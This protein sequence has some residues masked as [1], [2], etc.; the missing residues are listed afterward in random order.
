MRLLRSVVWAGVLVM[1]SVAFSQGDLPIPAPPNPNPP[2]ERPIFL[3]PP[4][5]PPEVAPPIIAPD[6]RVV[7]PKYEESRA[8]TR[9]DTPDSTA[10]AEGFTSGGDGEEVGKIGDPFMLPFGSKGE[11]VAIAFYSGDFVPPPN[12]R[13]Q[14]ALRLLA[15]QR[16]SE[17]APA[18]GL[19]RPTVDALILFNGRL[20]EGMKQQMEEAG[21][22]FFRFYPYSA[23]QAR[24]PVDLLDRLE[25]TEAVRWVG[26]PNPVQKTA[27][28]AIAYINQNTSEREW[29]YITGFG[30]DT[31][32][33]LRNQLQLAGAEIVS[34]HA[35]LEVYTVRANSFQLSQIVMIPDAMF[36]EWVGR[37]QA[38]HTESMASHNADRLWGT[39]YDG[40]PVGGRSIK[41]GV[42]DS[43]MNTAH[44]DFANLSG[45]MFGFN[46]TTE[47]NWWNDLNAHGTHV[48]GTFFGQG[49]AQFRYRGFASGFR[50]HSSLVYDLLHSKVFRQDSFAEGNSMLEG[51][52]DMRGRGNEDIKRRIYNLSGGASSSLPGTDAYAREADQA[53]VENVLPVIAAGNGGPNASTIRT[54]GKAK[55][56]LTVGN[57][58]DDWNGSGT[59]TTDTMAPDSSRGPIEDTRFKP[60]VVAH[61][62]WIDST[63]NTDNAGYRFGWNGTSMAAPHVAGLAATLVQRYDW[64][65]WAIRSIIMGT[66]IDLGHGRNN[67][68]LGK[69]D[70]LLSHLAWNGGWETWFWHNGG[71]GD[72]RYIDV[73][74]PSGVSRMRVVL[75]YPDPP[76]ASGASIALKNDLDLYLQTGTLTTNASGQWSSLSARNNVEIIEVSN[77]STGTYRVKVHT[78]NLAE[79]SSQP[80]AFTI[81]WTL[82]SQSPNLNLS[83]SAPVAVK[84]ST[85][86]TVT[87]TASAGSYVASGV[88][89]TLTVPSGGLTRNGLT[90]KRRA[91]NGGTETVYFNGVFGKNMGNIGHTLSRSF[92]WSM[93]SGASEGTR[94]VRMSVASINGGTAQI[95]RTVIVDG[96]APTNWQNFVPT[97]WVSTQTPTC[98]IQVQDVLAGLDTGAIYY[99]YYTPNTGTQGPFNA[100]TTA[101]NG[102]TALATLR[103]MNVPF[104]TESSGSQAQI[105]FR[106][107]DRAGNFS[108]SGWQ[109]VRIDTTAPADWQN[110]TPSSVVY[111]T[112]ITCTVRVRD[113]LSGL[114]TSTAFYRYSSDGGSTWSGWV[115][116]SA[117]GANGTTALQTITATNVPFPNPSTTQNKI[118]FA[119]RDE[120]GNWGYSPEYT[121]QTTSTFTLTNGSATYTVNNTFGSAIRTGSLGG[122]SDFNAGNGDKLYQHWWWY[123]TQG[124]NREFALSN[125]VAHNQP[126]ANRIELTYEE[127]V[128]TD[129]SQVYR[130]TLIYE[131][132][133][134][135][136]DS[137]KVDILSTIQNLSSSTRT[138]HLYHY[139]DF[140]AGTTSDVAQ[141]RNPN[142]IKQVFGDGG[143]AELRTT[144]SAS[145]WEVATY[146]TLRSKLTNTSADDLSNAT[147]VSGDVTM[148]FQWTRSLT[149]GAQFATT[150]TQA[151]NLPQ[152]V[153][154]VNGDCIVDDADLLEVLFNFGATGASPADLNC[155]GIV[156]DADL[157]IVLFNF[158]SN[159]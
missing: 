104:N 5:Q 99:W 114:T 150:V 65:A 35:D 31:N 149:S 121:V 36:V 88:H 44:Q 18:S 79:G 3:P 87:G 63:H 117:T 154:D 81:H 19:A 56:S 133:S 108:D 142:L 124:S 48:S 51:M 120:A 131:L 132:T 122:L 159:C 7:A 118:Q 152:L 68:G 72:V 151:L 76:A 109:Q 30:P 46:R 89:A 96:T 32:N 106:A 23:Y 13:I 21:I 77:P 64:P 60:D 62:R 40:R 140:F 94:T 24:I 14:P 95:D 119:I 80:W 25:A 29:F 139:A 112:R 137:A 9:P 75:V 57:I 102:T 138:V 148:A 39:D 93:T 153:G 55:G 34:Y 70:A 84:P 66:A 100:T 136:S 37:P 146:P 41:L 59:N 6:G 12:E 98:T 147:S 8:L 125:L 110:F 45:G 11:R 49:N 26:L 16:A 42:A 103:A 61:G 17:F 47:Q 10:P 115:V 74:V 1:A 91:P 126:S 22:Q 71:T 130:I 33:L 4:P 123:R 50:E 113:I 54:P 158:G 78:Y 38:L 157:L 128:D 73:N 86:F 15:A 156:D 145:R 43:G 90:Y 82:G 97:S 52:I 143:C 27:P 141:V 20:A 58:W 127:P 155:D 2:L 53:F 107:Y 116:A 67:Q 134:A 111:G 85:N 129:P 105:Y 92:D 69:V 135:G 83:L 101:S 28:E 144:Q